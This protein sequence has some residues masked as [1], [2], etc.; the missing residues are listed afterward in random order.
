[1]KSKT[2]TLPYSKLFRATFSPEYQQSYGSVLILDDKY[3]PLYYR[4]Q[5]RH[6]AN[7]RD[8][9]WVQVSCNHIGGKA[10]HRNRCRRRLNAAV[11]EALK[12]VKHGLRGRAL[13]GVDDSKGNGIE[14]TGT[15][16]LLG[17]RDL[18]EADWG[19]IKKETNLLV[20]RLKSL[21]RGGRKGMKFIEEGKFQ[22]SESPR[23]VRYPS[24]QNIRKTII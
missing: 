17:M 20:D 11:N 21:N 4:T 19:F 9:L 8:I 1:M 3:H 18:L 13:K 15:L 23:T 24:T 12:D 5:A 6:L 10:V 16:K 14:L 7:P 2:L 22:T